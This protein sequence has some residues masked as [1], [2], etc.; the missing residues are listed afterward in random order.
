MYEIKKCN[1][2]II[3]VSFLFVFVIFLFS[4]SEKERAATIEFLEPTFHELN[5]STWNPGDSLK[6]TV[7]A[8]IPKGRMIPVDFGLLRF[9]GSGS[10]RP[11]DILFRE[12]LES[13]NLEET[14]VINWKLPNNLELT[15]ENNR[16]I[17]MYARDPARQPLEDGGHLPVNIR[18]IEKE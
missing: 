7:R 12:T 1:K 5:T 2:F 10:L 8:H 3:P 9:D 16:Y 18:I 14:F 11:I 13:N 6:F 4:C 15:S 17:L